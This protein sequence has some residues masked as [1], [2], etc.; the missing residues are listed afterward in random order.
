MLLPEQD[1]LEKADSSR[2]SWGLF[3]AI[4]YGNAQL[5]EVEKI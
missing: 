2:I 4:A 1:Q 5:Q 3:H